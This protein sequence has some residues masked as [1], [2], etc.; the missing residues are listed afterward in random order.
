MQR[1][2]R[3]KAMHYEFDRRTPP[4]LTVRQREPFVIETEDSTSGRLRSAGVLPTLENR[5]ELAFTPAKANPVA[6]PVY[7]EGAMPGDLVVVDIE[8]IVVDSQGCT[9]VR[10]GEG[11]LS[12][13]LTWK[14]A[15]AEPYTRILKH[16]PGRDGI[17]HS[18]TVVFSERFS[19]PLQPFIGTLALAPEREVET[20]IIGQ[21]S[22]GG[23]LDCRDFAVGSKVF[24]NCYNEGGLL[25]VGDVHGSQGDGE[26]TGTANETRAEVTLSCEVKKGK[27]LPGI[28]VETAES[29]ITVYASR[30]LED[31]VRHATV[32]LMDWIVT[33]YGVGKR[34]AYL[35]TSVCPYFRIHVYQMVN[36]GRISYVAG[37]ELPRSLLS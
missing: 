3:Q 29:I 9:Y 4:A 35:L 10:A 19:W 16:L 7:I 15:A 2:P 25:F 17:L 6:G 33:E 23:N 1:I 22:W 30:P 34:D 20:S 11:P 26:F 12:D 14:E 36:I 13:S 27:R 5:P 24:L 21:G 32:N 28:R 37:A 31:A 18:G 8:D